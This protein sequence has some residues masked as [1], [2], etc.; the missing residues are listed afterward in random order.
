MKMLIASHNPN[1][2]KELHLLF[3]SHEIE[4]VGLDALHDH[5]D[6]DETGYTFLENA[7]IKAK[8]YANKYQIASLADDSGIVVDALDGKPGI[9]SKRYSGE[10]DHANNI[11]LLQ[12]MKDVNNRKAAFIAV[13]AI[14]FP[15][16]KTYD[17]T[18]EVKGT[19]ANALSGDQG[20]G[21]DPLFIP[22]GYD[23]TMAE[24]GLPIK[25]QISHRARAMQQLKERI[26][27][28]AHYK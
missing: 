16:G 6:V 10:G 17:F 18:G 3:A 23:K 11:K 13:I 15:D 5:E 26:D 22:F 19:I 2:V 9:Y 25:N 27:E 24:L 12:E 7:M 8:H 20:F 14:A 21:Y 28:I 1:K 4:L